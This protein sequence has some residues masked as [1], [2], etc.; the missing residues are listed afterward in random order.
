[1]AVSR[2]HLLKLVHWYW[3]YFATTHLSGATTQFYSLSHGSCSETLYLGLDMSGSEEHVLS[4]CNPK[5]P[6][7]TG[8]VPKSVMNVFL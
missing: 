5:L 8:Q 7:Q 3:Y 1:M 4:S 6:P 2:F